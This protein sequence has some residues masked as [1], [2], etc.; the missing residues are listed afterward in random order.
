[1]MGGE[2]ATTEVAMQ[3]PA[4]PP[5]MVPGGLDQKRYGVEK[6]FDGQGLAMIPPM[7]PLTEASFAPEQM[8][9]AET[10]FER[11]VVVPLELIATFGHS[12][13]DEEGGDNFNDMGRQFPRDNKNRITDNDDLIARVNTY[14]YDIPSGSKCRAYGLAC[15]TLGCYLISKRKTV[16]AGYFGHYVSMER[17]MLCPAGRH[18]LMS[19]EEYWLDPILIDDPNE[20]VRVIGTKLI[21]T[22]PENHV[23]GA[24]RVGLGQKEDG[25][26]EAVG[27]DG[28]PEYSGSDGDFVL[29]GQGRHVLDSSRYQEPR[30]QK[31]E[32]DRVVLGP[33][34]VLYI[35]EGFIGGAYERTTG[36]YK[37]FQPGPPYLLHEKDWED[38]AIVKRD[39]EGFK[40]G[41]ID[42]IT[43]KDGEM[44]GAFEQ[45]SG[46]YQILPPGKTYMLHEKDFV[47][48][49][50][51]K[52]KRTDEFTLGPYTFVTV[53]SDEVA[54]AE[55]RKTGEFILLAAGRTY[56]LNEK[57]FA[58]PIR[59]KRDK[60]V[61]SCGPMTFLTLQEGFLSGAYRCKDGNFEEFQWREDG[62]DTQFVLHSRDYHSLTVV[63][64]Y[65]KSVQ[66][67]GPNKIVTIPEGFCGVF[68]KEGR[69]EIKD[70]GFYRV[71]A[72]YS[73]CDNI[74]LHVKSERFEDHEFRTKDSVRMK[75]SFLVIWRVDDPLLT[76]K[77]PGELEDLQAEFRSKA[78]LGL[79]SLLRTHSRSALRPTR[80]DVL[81]A[82]GAAGEDMD[83]QHLEEAVKG[84][85]Q[86]SNQVQRD[87]EETSLAMMNRASLEGGW[88]IEVVSVKIDSLDLADESIIADM[89]SMAQSQLA[90]KRKQMEGRAELAAAEVD[91]EAA[92]QNAKADAEVK[93]ARSES[94]A[95]VRVAEARAQSEISLM[96]STNA[97]RAQA[98]CKKIELDMQL[99]LE[100]LQ[101]A[102]D[103][104]KATRL[105]R[106]EA[107][108]KKIELEMQQQIAETQAAIEET[109]LHAK[110]KAAETE[111]ASILAL[112]N[113]NYEKGRKE[114]EVQGMMAPQEL[115]IKRMEL[116]IE[117]MR[118][119]A[120]AAWRHPEDA[121]RAHLHLFWEEM[122]PFMKL[123][124]MR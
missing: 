102:L 22:V 66:D 87:T 57:D 68:E 64:K 78:A 30:I 59:A 122:K 120:A 13:L 12:E 113:A 116:T 77:W 58:P 55:S 65:S 88:G 28:Q 54:G 45:S 74:P 42:F 90:T 29:F 63:N 123:G 94:Q 95:K 92:M 3:G 89:E 31:L 114:Q 52:V 40:L 24:I 53:Q 104:S 25:A 93:Q 107:E 98:E 37:L 60:H 6:T 20:A 11:E 121:E 124:P 110:L 97:A 2:E 34:T 1:M 119:F 33:V 82:G 71:A 41:P 16:P 21:I 19:D 106:A 5:G 81:L 38:I 86:A 9:M 18:V 35:K 15:C 49:A 7:P 17:H 118:H 103:E 100:E 84:S 61:V 27:E 32:N 47:V 69:I 76:A 43:V 79:V 50:N 67:F 56:Q 111:A 51:P 112:A 73:I 105:A 85:Q 36:Q 72:E 26:E 48:A 14:S 109:K 39:L 62:T 96:G 101:A 108:A 117:G 115:E 80:N 91:R 83:P 75:I 4:E 8:T 70:A 44:S 46:Q 10:L 99:Q 23:A